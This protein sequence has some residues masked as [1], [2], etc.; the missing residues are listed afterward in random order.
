MCG[1]AEAL[2]MVLPVSRPQFPH[3]NI[4]INVCACVCVL[5]GSMHMS[6][7]TEEAR[8]G[9]LD[10]LELELQAFGAGKQTEVLC[11][12]VPLTTESYLKP[13]VSSNRRAKRSLL[14][15]AKQVIFW[16]AYDAR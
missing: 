2:E 10:A 6:A 12:Q 4:F 5:C 1:S 15:K 11:N 7:I 13:P 16:M 8:R 3:L 14:G 9:R